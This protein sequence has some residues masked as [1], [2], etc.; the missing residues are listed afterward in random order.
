MKFEWDARKARWNEVKHGV[1]FTEACTV[2]ED[3]FASTVR[4]PD[5][6]VGESRYLTFGVSCSGRP[7]VVAHTER[8]DNIRIISARVLTLSERRAYEER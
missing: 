3:E 2:F 8:E 1:S 7:L 6:S 4:D 5:H